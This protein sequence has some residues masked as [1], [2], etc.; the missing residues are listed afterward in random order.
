MC[1]PGVSGATL[2]RRARQPI[3]SSP[4]LPPTSPPPTNT[5]TQ[6]SAGISDPYEEPLTP[7]VVLEPYGEGEPPT[8]HP[9]HHSLL[10]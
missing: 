4:Q 8:P 6:P 9:T 10:H 1:A 2:L 5:P 3:S 7:E